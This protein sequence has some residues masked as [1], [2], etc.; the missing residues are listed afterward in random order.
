MAIEIQEKF[1]VRAPIDAV[2]RF[3]MDPDLVATCMPGA[4]LERV[5]DDRTFL[6]RIR[7]RVGAVTASY[8]GRVRLTD[9]DARGYS[10]QMV[11]EGRETGGGTATGTLSSRLRSL[12]DGQTEVVAEAC[13]DVTGRLVQVGRGMLQGVSHQLFQQF[14]ARTRERLELGEGAGGERAQADAN[15]PIRVVSLLLQ[16]LWS[17]IARIFRRLRHRS[18]A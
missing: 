9:V 3:V 18:A 12:P 4:E 5:L 11:A 6:G 7:I 8:E 10:V 15:E 13:V 16:A 2:W 17:A 14:A 1:Q